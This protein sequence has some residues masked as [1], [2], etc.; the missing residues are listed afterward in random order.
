MGNG[1]LA[2]SLLQQ[3][4]HMRTIIWVAML[5]KNI[6]SVRWHFCAERKLSF[7]REKSFL[8]CEFIGSRWITHIVGHS[9][10]ADDSTA[11]T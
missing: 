7:S 10:Q 11:G 4:W 1:L 9:G 3:N 8:K 6:R 2:C 5:S